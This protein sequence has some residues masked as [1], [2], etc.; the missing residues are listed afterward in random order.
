M[1]VPLAVASPLV[2]ATG[3]FRGIFCCR[4]E[5]GKAKAESTVRWGARLLP[6]RDG[7]AYDTTVDV[8]VLQCNNKHLGQVGVK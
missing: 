5:K 2:V 7:G 4:A 6:Y 3:R 1:C 8:V